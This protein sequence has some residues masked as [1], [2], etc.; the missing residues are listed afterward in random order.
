MILPYRLKNKS[1]YSAIKLTTSH[2]I[3]A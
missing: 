2:Y 3:P 1:G